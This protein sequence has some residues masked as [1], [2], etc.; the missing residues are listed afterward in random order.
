LAE[1]YDDPGK[2]AKMPGDLKV[3][4]FVNSG[5]EANGNFCGVS[6]FGNVHN[7]NERDVLVLQDRWNVDERVAGKVNDRSFLVDQ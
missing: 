1:F 7:A 2:K 3:C 4:Y 5:S 6:S